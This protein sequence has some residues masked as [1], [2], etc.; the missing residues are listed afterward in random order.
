LIGEGPTQ[1]VAV[2][3][4]AQLGEDGQDEAAATELEA[5]VLEKVRR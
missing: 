2:V 5:E 4:I 3:F 1:G